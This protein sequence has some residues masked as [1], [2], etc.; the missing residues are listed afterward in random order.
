[1]KRLFFNMKKLVHTLR[2]G[3]IFYEVI[4]K[5]KPSG[6]IGYLLLSP[7]VSFRYFYCQNSNFKYLNKT[8]H[9]KVQNSVITRY[10]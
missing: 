3:L 9:Q 1:M 10:I 2:Y 4:L 5:K 6:G 7:Y 8:H